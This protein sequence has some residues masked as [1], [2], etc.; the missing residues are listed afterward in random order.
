MDEVTHDAT[1]SASEATGKHVC[2]QCAY[3]PVKNG[4]LTKG[5]WIR[6]G[7]WAIPVIF[8]AAAMFVTVNSLAAKT[9]DH[10]DHLRDLDRATGELSTE[11]RVT[12]EKVERV[13]KKVDKVDAK[14]EKIDDK[15][16]VAS[17]DLAAI[18]EKLKISDGS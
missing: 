4:H 10:D 14:V 1:T 12:T 16:D 8:M 2:Q 13:E 11:Q 15:M 9:N 6:I 3:E 17:T 7:I 18:K 5:D